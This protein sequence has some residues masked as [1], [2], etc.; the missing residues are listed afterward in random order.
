MDI[1]PRGM[2]ATTTRLSS[3]ILL[4]ARVAIARQ[5][6]LQSARHGSL[7]GVHVNLCATVSHPLRHGCAQPPRVPINKEVQGDHAA[8]VCPFPASV[9]KSWSE[10]SSAIKSMKG[11]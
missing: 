10:N 1:E 8:Y 6:Y 7:D 9:R 5:S 3:I 11:T 2:P 4:R